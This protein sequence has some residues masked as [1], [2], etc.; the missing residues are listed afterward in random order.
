MGH[1][2]DCI[3]MRPNCFSGPHGFSASTGRPQWQAP[4]A[5]TSVPT[6]RAH[7]SGCEQRVLVG[8]DRVL[9]EKLEEV[10]RSVRSG[11]TMGPPTGRPLVKFIEA[12]GDPSFAAAAG[13]KRGRAPQLVGLARP[14]ASGDEVDCAEIA[15]RQPAHQPPTAR[16]R[17]SPAC[18]YGDHAARDRVDCSCKSRGWPCPGGATLR[19]P[20]CSWD[21]R[22][23]ISL[24]T[25]RSSPR[26]Q[27]SHVPPRCGRRREPQPRDRVF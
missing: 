26:H 1:R 23:C 13:P 9:S 14:A 11:W 6:R 20:F 8:S 3:K 12:G 18:R 5:A 19:E 22:E 27:W 16:R 2:S 25:G 24:A 17:V 4:R 10:M 7:V 15:Q 21:R